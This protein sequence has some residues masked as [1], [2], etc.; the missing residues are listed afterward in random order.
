V[1]EAAEQLVA[2]IMVDDRFGH[3]CAEAGHALAEP[4]RYAA[5][6]QR[7]IGAAGSFCHGFLLT[8]TEEER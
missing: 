4:S 8:R 1:G 2:A 6:V 3:H 7:E 5:A